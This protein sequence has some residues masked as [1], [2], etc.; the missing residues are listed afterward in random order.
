MHFGSTLF[1]VVLFA[2][3]VGHNCTLDGVN[4]VDISDD[5]HSR[6][7]V[8]EVTL[9]VG[10][11]LAKQDGAKA[12]GFSGEAESSNAGEEADMGGHWLTRFS[13][14]GCPR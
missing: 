1:F 7:V 9:S 8:G 4:V 2:L 10:V 3:A 6:P 12:A 13:D 5:G 14:G 11:P